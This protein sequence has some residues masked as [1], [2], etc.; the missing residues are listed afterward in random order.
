[1]NAIWQDKEI[2]FDLPFSQLR[3]RPG[4]KILD[5]LD[6]VEDTKGNGGTRGRLAV[7][8]LRIIWHSISSPRINLCIGYNCFLSVTT[9]VVRSALRGTAE[10]LYILTTYNNSRYEFIFTNLIPGN[11]RHFTSVMGVH[12]A[13]ISSRL[14][15]EL[16][17]RGA[18]VHNKQLKVLPSEQ[19]HTSQHGVWNLSSDTGNLGTMIITNVRIVWFADINET[20]NVSLPYIQIDNIRI[21]DSKFGEALVIVTNGPGGGYVLGFR[22]DPVDKLK[23]LLKELHTLHSIYVNKPVFGVQYTWTN[24]PIPDTPE[25]SVDEDFE[26]IGEPRGE[27]GPTI[28]LASQAAQ[29]DGAKVDETPVYSPYLGLA[30]EPPREGFTL[31]G[32]WEVLPS[33]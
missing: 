6:S 32:L 33:M 25:K 12:K 31:K 22:V 28:Y 27:M 2:R 4:E 1:M 29:K 17:L 20:F 26:E 18:I 13:Y 30:I 5:R 8:N 24:Q 9:K 19:I 16:K 15:R 11:M 23:P 14:Y 21:R 3:M 7:T 10:A